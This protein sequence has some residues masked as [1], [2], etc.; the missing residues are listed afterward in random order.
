MCPVRSLA[1]VGG[2]VYS[3]ARDGSVK[4]WAA[5]QPSEQHLQAWRDAVGGLTGS[6]SC[7]VC[8]LLPDAT[9]QLLRWCVQQGP[10]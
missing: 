8:S 4:G 9:C 10:G 7:C 6:I 2:V 5:V 1:Q 3:L